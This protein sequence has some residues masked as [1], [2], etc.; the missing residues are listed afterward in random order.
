MAIEITSES[1]AVVYGKIG[2][3][4]SIEIQ[5]SGT[6]EFEID[7]SDGRGESVYVTIDDIREIVRIFDE[8]EAG[9]K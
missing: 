8:M 6:V 5:K 7:G 3:K 9:G 1:D 2:R 4:I